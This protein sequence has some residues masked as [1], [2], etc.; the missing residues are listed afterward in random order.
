MFRM[1]SAVVAM[2]MRKQ[3]RGWQGVKSHKFS[4]GDRVR[5]R[6]SPYYVGTT[7]VVCHADIPHPGY[8][9]V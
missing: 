9:H 5:L 1:L 7:G 3:P 4:P 8:L 2:A 6:A